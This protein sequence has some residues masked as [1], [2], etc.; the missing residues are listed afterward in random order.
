MNR[1]ENFSIYSQ[2]LRYTKC[3]Q[4]AELKLLVLPAERAE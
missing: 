2:Y 4:R 3:L 1:W